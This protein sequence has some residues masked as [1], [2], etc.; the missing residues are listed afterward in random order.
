MP[1]FSSYKFQNDRIRTEGGVAFSR[2]LAFLQYFC[3]F[4]TSK[5]K[6]EIPALL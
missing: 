3:N 1:S 6:F 2:N 4:W 5:Q